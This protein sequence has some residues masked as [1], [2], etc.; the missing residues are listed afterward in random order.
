[1]SRQPG[2]ESAFLATGYPFR[3]RGALDVY[4]AAFREV[5]LQARA[6]RRCG[7]AAIDLAHTAAGVYDGFFEFRLSPWD[8]A[9][10]ALLILEAG[11]ALTDLDGGDR[12]V[13]AGNVLAGTPGVVAGLRRAVG[14][15]ASEELIERLAPADPAVRGWLEA[16]EQPA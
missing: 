10:G 5:F 13:A 16:V 14:R 1:V 3:A 7:S 6:I 2:L 12:Y 4:L 11:G 8:V 9:A 15:H